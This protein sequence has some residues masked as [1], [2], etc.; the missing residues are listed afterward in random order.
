MEEVWKI[1]SVDAAYEIS[2][3]GRCRNIKS[4]KILRPKNERYVRY[5]LSQ[6][7]YLAHRLVAFEFVENENNYN[8]VNHI[9][10]NRYNNKA[11]NLEW[12]TRKQNIQHSW[13]NGLARPQMG[14]CKINTAKLDDMHILTIATLLNVASIDTLANWIP[15]DSSMCSKRRHIR[16]I[17]TG[18]RW[19]HLTRL[20]TLV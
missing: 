20:F 9:D 13:K 18:E 11:S 5:S 10:G 3:Y 16:R 6:K 4:G 2:S 14:E 7:Y 12:C 8:E 15:L 17:A 19:P 1:S